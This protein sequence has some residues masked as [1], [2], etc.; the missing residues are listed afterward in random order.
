MHIALL[1][2]LSTVFCS[3]CARAD[4]DL[5]HGQSI[6]SVDLESQAG[7][8]AAW[9]MFFLTQ[10]FE[11]DFKHTKQCHPYTEV[12]WYRNGT[13]SCQEPKNNATS[14]PYCEAPQDRALLGDYQP[15][16]WD[17]APNEWVS[18]HVYIL[19]FA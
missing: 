5:L 13:R 6:L 3:V 16:H 4:R 14:Q 19:S 15:E 17:I 10:C 11:V 18:S 2:V 7:D 1:L 9:E 12:A 8:Q